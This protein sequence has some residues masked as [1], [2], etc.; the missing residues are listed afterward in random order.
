M[1]A[2]AGSR[3]K[4]IA[5]SFARLGGKPLVDDT[6]VGLERALWEAPRAI[7]A[8]GVE[9][10]PRF[11]YGNRILLDLL[12]MAASDFIGTVSQHLAEPVLREEQ[13]R[14]IDGLTRHDIADVY[15]VVGIAAN[16]RRFAIANAQI[17]NLVDRHGGRH[18]LGTT[19]ADWQ[20]LDGG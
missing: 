19:F 17:W 4:L 1:A 9:P 18:G 7:A 14:M 12:G 20:F 2:S 8:H 5:D 15:A 13:Q 11:F 16:G 3:L 10:E 6:A